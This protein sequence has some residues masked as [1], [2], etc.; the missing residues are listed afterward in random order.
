[1][2]FFAGFDVLSLIYSYLDI[3]V[4]RKN[5]ILKLHGPNSKQILNEF[6]LPPECQSLE[7]H[8]IHCYSFSTIRKLSLKNCVVPRDVQFQSLMLET[9]SLFSVDVEDRS[10]EKINET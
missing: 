8:S 9:L 3:T 2:T 10:F 5:G 6:L 1:M 7:I 4:K